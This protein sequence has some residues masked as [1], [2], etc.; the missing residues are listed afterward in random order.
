MNCRGKAPRD[1]PKGSTL[2]DSLGRTAYEDRR[3]VKAGRYR[4]LRAG[5][6]PGGVCPKTANF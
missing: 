6:D 1:T 5:F 4:R 2:L 3:R